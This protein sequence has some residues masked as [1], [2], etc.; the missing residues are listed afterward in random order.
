MSYKSTKFRYISQK[1]H[2][3]SQISAIFLNIAL[4]I[5]FSIFR[6]ISQYCTLGIMYNSQYFA[7]QISQYFAIHISQ[8]FLIFRYIS[9]YFPIYFAIF[10]YIS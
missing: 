5:Y 7:L 1:F 10:R 4:W 3:I 9:Q 8:Y 2:Y 6:Y